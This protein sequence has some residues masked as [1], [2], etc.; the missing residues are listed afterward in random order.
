MRR[1]AFIIAGSIIFAGGVALG[2]AAIAGDGDI[3]SPEPKVI[4]STPLQPARLAHETGADSQSALQFPNANEVDA[5]IE[6][7]S[8][9]PATRGS[10]MA[11]WNDITGAN[12][13]LLDVSTS[14]SFN[15]YVEGYHDLDV[16]N[17]RGRVVTGLQ[18][19]TTYYYRVR[20]YTGAGAGSYSEAMMAPT[21]AT[22]GLTIHATFDSS[23]T[24]RPNSA[25]IQATIN[26][27]ISIYESLFTDPITIQIRFRYATTEP[28]GTTALTG[29]SHSLS[30][31]YGFLWNT[32]INALR[33]D[34][35][36]H[37]D[38][39]AIASLPASALNQVIVAT[40]AN[41]RA[42]RQNT[43]PAM[44]PNG[45]VGQGGPYDGIVTLN[46]ATSFQFSRP[47]NANKYDAQRSIEHEI[48]Q[49]IGFLYGGSEFV[50]DSLF[51]WSSPGHRNLVITGTRYFSIDGGVTNIVNFNQTAGG[52]FS[53]WR[54]A[55]C[56]QAH[57][58]VQNAFMCKG[59][60]SD[61]SAT[62]P[63]GINLDVIGYDLVTAS[64]DVPSDFNSD[65]H[66][67]YLLYNSGTRQTVI[68][69]MNNNVRLGSTFGPTLPGGW[70]VAAV[71]DFNRDEHPDYLLRNPATRQTVIWYMNNNVRIDSTYGPT[72][73]S[74]WSVVAAADFNADG[75]PDYLLY[76]AST[77]GTVIWYLRNNARIGS[78]SCPTLPG[79]WQVAAV[80]DFN[81]DGHPDFLLIKAATRET[82]IWHMNNNVRLSSIQGPT[83]PGGWSAVGAA[84][85][86]ADGYPDYLLY[87]A[88][89]GATV[90]W[91]MR[92]NVR[93]GSATGPTLPG[94][95]TLVAP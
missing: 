91:Y 16:G 56:P 81:R 42:L 13:Y 3:N 39:V 40:S 6:T 9:A 24:G 33:A 50:P 53:G 18:P 54:S 60:S 78:A 88:N 79:G 23:I 20:P 83:P 80:G 14:D 25:A 10:F 87:N 52:D 94:G 37:N 62:S 30:V 5:A 29:I 71:E 44:F 75:Y 26:R 45:T 68:W 61:I 46:S 19:G 4:S 15:S 66:S 27:A 36:T 35:T 11:S 59:Q 73:P 22:T 48:D 74:G 28:D 64:T 1:R 90:V 58:Y 63:E 2:L 84:D 72:P 32:G 38:D 51:S 57:P 89:T 65:G 67:D 12:G 55:A 34:A 77:R 76:N 69:Y 82:V 92:D 43:P 47:T 93:I 21:A 41:W 17:V 7:V 31:V 49:V 85:F 95:W 86:N 70:Q 8:S